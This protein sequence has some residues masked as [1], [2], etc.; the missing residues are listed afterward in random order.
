MEIV[1]IFFLIILKIIKNII[2]TKSDFKVKQKSI[3]KRVTCATI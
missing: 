1:G 2:Y 3:N